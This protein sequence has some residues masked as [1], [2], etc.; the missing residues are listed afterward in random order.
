VAKDVSVLAGGEV[1][2]SVLA[3]GASVEAAGAVVMAESRL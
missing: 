2:A 1:G 3:A